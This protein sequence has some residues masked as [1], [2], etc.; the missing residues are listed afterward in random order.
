MSVAAG[1]RSLQI[2]NTN[3]CQMCVCVC[4]CLNVCVPALCVWAQ[5]EIIGLGV[6]AQSEGRKIVIE[7]CVFVCVCIIERK[8]R[9][10]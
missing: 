8:E 2:T 5:R 1:E 7:V 9:H 6:H 3:T 4:V 10:T